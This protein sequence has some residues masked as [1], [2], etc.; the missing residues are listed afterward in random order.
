MLLGSPTQRSNQERC[1]SWLLWNVEGHQYT[2]VK[3]NKTVR[4]RDGSFLCIWIT[5][6][7]LLAVNMKIVHAKSLSRERQL[8]RLE[9]SKIEDEDEFLNSVHALEE[10]YSFEYEIKCWNSVIISASINSCYTRI[11]QE[12]KWFQSNRLQSRYWNIGRQSNLRTHN[13][14]RF[15]TSKWELSPRYKWWWGTKNASFEKKLCEWWW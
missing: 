13:K 15:G 5:K 9:E 2:H 8:R 12:T 1:A 6:S 3:G 11:T 7:R 10:I 14:V 4:D